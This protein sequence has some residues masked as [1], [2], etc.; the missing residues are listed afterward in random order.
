MQPAHRLQP[1]PP[2]TVFQSS[3]APQ[4]RCYRAIRCQRLGTA[5]VSILTG[6]ESRCY[7]CPS[8]GCPGHGDV[9]ILTG[10]EEPVLLDTSLSAVAAG[11]LFQSSPAP[12]SRCYVAVAGRMRQEFQSSPAP[13][14]RCYGRF[15]KQFG[16]AAGSLMGGVGLRQELLLHTTWREP[17]G[18]WTRAWGSR[19]VFT[20]RPVGKA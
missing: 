16:T 11:V 6:S 15:V 8:N 12:E 20:P 9:S 17:P 2:L 19:H 10:S 18:K 5:A 4:S 13:E 7:N 3:P 1:L 14:S